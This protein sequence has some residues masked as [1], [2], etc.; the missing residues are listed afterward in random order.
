MDNYY[1]N[2]SL[3][4]LVGGLN[5]WFIGICLGFGAFDLEFSE[6]YPYRAAKDHHKA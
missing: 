3:G 5:I 2:S 4:L 1:F 6:K